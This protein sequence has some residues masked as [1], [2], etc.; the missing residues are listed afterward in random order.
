LR[1]GGF[2]AGRRLR[3]RLTSEHSLEPP[4]EPP[5]R[6]A[7]V[8]LSGLLRRRRVAV[9]FIGSFSPNDRAAAHATTFS[10]FVVVF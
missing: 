9:V 10:R 3:L 7:V 5:G 8:D 6:E 2:A 4:T 1:T